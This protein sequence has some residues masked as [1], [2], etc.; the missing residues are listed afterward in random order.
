VAGGVWGG[1]AGGVGRRLG[2]GGGKAI[3]CNTRYLAS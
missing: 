3:R 2:G 1:D